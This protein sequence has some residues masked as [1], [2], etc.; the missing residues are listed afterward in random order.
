MD[1]PLRLHVSERCV[2]F[3][4]DLIVEQAVAGE[5]RIHAS[6]GPALSGLDQLAAPAAP[7][8]VRIHVPAFDVPDGRRLAA[9][10]I[11][12]GPGFKKSAEQAVTTIDD[13]D[14]LCRLVRPEF[15]DVGLMRA[16][17]EARPEDVAHARP[18]GV[19][20]LTDKSDMHHSYPR[21]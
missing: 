3:E 20:L 2:G 8:Q 1:Q 14:R 10:R 4:T 5:L 9:V 15:G 6:S 11:L 13:E 16:M 7:A 17:R 18:F 19:V 12:P 21:I